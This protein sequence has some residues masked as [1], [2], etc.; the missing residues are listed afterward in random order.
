[1]NKKEKIAIEVLKKQIKKL[2]NINENNVDNWSTSTFDYIKRYLGDCE[3]T[4]KVRHFHFSKLINMEI[5]NVYGGKP[6]PIQRNVFDIDKKTIAKELLEECISAIENGMMAV[7]PIDNFLS[8]FNSY[9]IGSAIG[10][11][12]LIIFSIGYYFGIE[13]VN[14]DAIIFEYKNKQLTDSLF[15]LKRKISVMPN[16]KYK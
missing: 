5:E 7:E 4:F 14:K 13:K 11:I 8:K 16:L 15:I 3:L 10:G 1:M 6:I 9:Q 12:L 2:E